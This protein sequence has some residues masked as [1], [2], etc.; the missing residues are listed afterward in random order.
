[1]A[2]RRPPVCD[3]GDRDPSPL[4]PTQSEPK[5]GENSPVSKNF[6]EPDL[7]FETMLDQPIEAQVVGQPQQYQQSQPQQFYAGQ[8]TAGQTDPRHVPAKFPS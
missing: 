5:T 7:D 8:S 2:V 6:L 1:M 4:M 3:S